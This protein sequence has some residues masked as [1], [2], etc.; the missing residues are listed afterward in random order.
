MLQGFSIMPKRIKLYRVCEVLTGWN[1][2][3][4]S[5]LLGTNYFDIL[6]NERAYQKITTKIKTTANGSTEYAKSHLH[7]I[8]TEKNTG[9]LKYDE[10]RVRTVA[11]RHMRS[12]M[13]TASFILV[14]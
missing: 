12:S 7:K 5:L 8:H 1:I 6:Y 11:Q 2:K 13:F 9:C 14:S 4:L 3:N 10:L